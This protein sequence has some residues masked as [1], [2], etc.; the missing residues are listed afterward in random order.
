M[1]EPGVQ[2]EVKGDKRIKAILDR[3]PKDLSVELGK[4]CLVVGDRYLAHHRKLRMRW[5]AIVNARP[6]PLAEG[7]RAA[8]ATEGSPSGVLKAFN[9]SMRGNNLA[10]L[11]M[12]IG[13]KNVILLQH[14]KGFTKVAYNRR[15]MYLPLVGA[16]SRTTGKV[17]KSMK[18]LRAARKLIVI[19]SRNG[20]VFLARRKRGKVLEFLFHGISS[21]TL[22][23]RLQFIQIW[24]KWGKTE[25]MKRFAYGL[26]GALKRAQAA[27]PR[28]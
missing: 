26:K 16:I 13:T 14:E 25:G 12:R 22:H 5:P 4:A 2:A 1:A 8:T 3:I 27:A 23:P 9:V 28:V 21:V 17:L 7:I 11:I 15:L 24:K 6:R 10:N 18:K 19:H 20:K